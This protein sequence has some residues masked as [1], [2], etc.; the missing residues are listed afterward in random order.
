MAETAAPT[1][2]VYVGDVAG[3]DDQEL[4]PPV[5][6]EG[7]TPE[8]CVRLADYAAADLVGVAA[9]TPAVTESIGTVRAG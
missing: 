2:T 3:G 9:G 6:V 5:T 4:P 8:A 7:Q 1:T